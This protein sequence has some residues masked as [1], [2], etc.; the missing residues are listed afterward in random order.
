VALAISDCRSGNQD[1]QMKPVEGYKMEGKENADIVGCGVSSFAKAEGFG[2]QKASDPE[3][4]RRK[5]L[6]ANIS[7]C[8]LARTE[9]LVAML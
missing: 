9:F 1:R 7:S 5:E 6:R 3:G 4:P 2:G 8:N